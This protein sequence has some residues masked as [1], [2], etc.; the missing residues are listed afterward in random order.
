MNDAFWTS[1]RS[2]IAALVAAIQAWRARQTGRDNQVAIGK[3]QTKQD[4]QYH[5][6][7]SRL[8]ELIDSMRNSAKAEGHA[9][10]VAAEQERAAEQIR[11]TQPKTGNE[12]EA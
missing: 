2:L 11:A 6:L 7:N 4:E 1:L 5:R 10:G 3:V 8:T 9:A 12:S